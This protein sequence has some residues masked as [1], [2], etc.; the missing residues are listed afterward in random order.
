MRNTNNKNNIVLNFEKLE[1][2][3]MLTAYCLLLTSSGIV[4][5]YGIA[6]CCCSL[7]LRGC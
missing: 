7:Y 1:C 6:Y 4:D 3:E 5:M 2:D